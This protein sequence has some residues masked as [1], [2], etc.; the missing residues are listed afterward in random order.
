MGNDEP[1]VKIHHPKP[2]RPIEVKTYLM[3]CQAKFTLYRNKKIYEIK[4]KKEEIISALKQN[5]IDIAKSKM[6]SIMRLEELITVYDILSPLCEVL[7]ERITY[8]LTATEPPA[9]VK[10]Q[11]DT[12]I[13]ASSRIEMDDLYKLR[14][15]VQKKYGIY[16][17]EAAD[18]NRDGLVNVNVIEKLK[19]KPASDVF[20][21]IRLKQICKEKKFNYEFPEDISPNGDGGFGGNPYDS[22]G[23]NPYDSNFGNNM[24]GGGMPFNQNN[25]QNP[26]ETNNNMMGN[27]GPGNDFD[28]YMKKSSHNNFQN[29]MSNN[30]NNN[31][32]GNPY[33]HSFGG[34]PYNT[35]GNPYDNNNMNKNSR[36]NASNLGKSKTMNNNN[37]NN[38]GSQLPTPFGSNMQGNPYDNNFDNNGSMA[39]PFNNGSKMGNS[40]LRGNAPNSS[41][42]GKSKMGWQ[43]RL[44]MEVKWVIVN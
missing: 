35:G 36:F 41:M 30:N 5:N 17:I 21:T 37:F 14:H 15:L 44:I 29:N 28:M 7:K 4:K 24:G 32:G 2:V 1:E 20:L 6:E 16:Y 42:M 38:N 33:D 34:N 18:Q 25:F 27:Q 22:P 19:V 39:D 10:A 40:K 26:Y 3:T 31:F 11:L 12:L 43:I 9:D 23:G 13:Y 8:L